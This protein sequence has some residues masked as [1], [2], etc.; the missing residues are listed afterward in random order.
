MT[1]D[2]LLPL[3]AVFVGVAAL[4]LAVTWFLVRRNRDPAEL[5]GSAATRSSDGEGASAAFGAAQKAAKEM[6]GVVD[7]LFERA[8]LDVKAL[9]AARRKRLRAASRLKKASA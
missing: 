1:G 9:K 6:L 4:N 8:G 5:L 3:A 2:Q 7:E